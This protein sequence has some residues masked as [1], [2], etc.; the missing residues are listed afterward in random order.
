MTGK[1]LVELSDPVPT[2]FV[3]N[4]RKTKLFKKISEEYTTLGLN[5]SLSN[6]IS[7]LEV[8]TLQALTSFDQ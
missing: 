6:L 7:V 8:W 3:F 2:R 1:H 5:L 4:L